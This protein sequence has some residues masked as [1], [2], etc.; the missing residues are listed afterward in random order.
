MEHIWL[1]VTAVNNQFDLALKYLK[2]SL[3]FALNRKAYSSLTSLYNNLAGLSKEPEEI[4]MFIDSAIYFAEKSGDLEDLQTSKQNKAYHLFHTKEFEDAYNY[5]WESFQL[6]DSILNKEKIEIA[7]EMSEKFETEQK[8]NTITQLQKENEIGQL[9]SSNKQNIITGLLIALIMFIIISNAF[10]KQKQKKQKLNN[11]LTLEQIKSDELLRNILPAEIAEELKWSGKSEAK[12]YN[13]VSVLFTD[14]VNFTG[15]SQEMSPT[16]LVQEIHANFT[17][18]DAIMEKHGI[19]KIKTIG[20]A[21]LAVCGLPH[22]NPQHAQRIVAAAID[23]QAYMQKIGGKFQI[24]IGVHSGPVVA[25]IVGIKKYAYDIWGDTVNTAARMEQNSLPGNINISGTTYE[26]IKSEFTCEYRG[27]IDAK[28][29][30]E[31][32]MYFVKN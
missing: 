24:R 3:K 32:D 22:E 7:A 25:G 21:Y 12:L 11:E 27:K 18:F 10:Y 13:Q 17:A 2:S 23:I 19:E 29:K 6:K 5:L 1:L 8:Q 26:L 28:N 14:F 15:I 30:G 9:K 20:D 31:I 16:E 4:S